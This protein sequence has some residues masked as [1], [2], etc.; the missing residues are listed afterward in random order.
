[1]VFEYSS[2]SVFF[3]A[4]RY[5]IRSED[6]SNVD[7]SC[8]SFCFSKISFF[9]NIILW[10]NLFF[11]KQLERSMED[12]GRLDKAEELR[13]AS[14]RT[15]FYHRFFITFCW[16][17]HQ[18]QNLSLKFYQKSFP[19]RSIFILFR[20]ECKCGWCQTV[21][22]GVGGYDF[23]EAA[24]VAHFFIQLCFLLVVISIWFWKLNLT[25]QNW[26]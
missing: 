6:R 10:L 11:Q 13:Q 3:H 23:K 14:E 12:M 8:L 20:S 7:W 19:R 9:K 15:Y 2:N 5:T 22:R 17:S 25:F 4:K 1:M 24:K 16:I 21:R 18:N 26:K